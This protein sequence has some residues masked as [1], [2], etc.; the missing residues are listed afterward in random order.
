MRSRGDS[1][2]RYRVKVRRFS[3]PLISASHPPL[4]TVDTLINN[5]NKKQPLRKGV[6]ATQEFCFAKLLNQKRLAFLIRS[7]GDSGFWSQTSMFA[8]V[9]PPT[10]TPARPC[11]GTLC[12]G[13]RLVIITSVLRFESPMLLAYS[14]RCNIRRIILAINAVCGAGGIRTPGT[15][16]R[17]DGLANR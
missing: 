1:N 6:A 16:L 2:P 8:P 17:Y 3:K 5:Y 10:H 9:T 15:R 12:Q 13:L 14:H 7:R 11:A 4:Q